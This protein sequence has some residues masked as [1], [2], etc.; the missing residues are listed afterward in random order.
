MSVDIISV[1]N[2]I[3]DL[4]SFSSRHLYHKPIPHHY[5]LSVKSCDVQSIK[6]RLLMCSDKGFRE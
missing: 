4:F 2:K 3:F 6:N 5:L 1:L